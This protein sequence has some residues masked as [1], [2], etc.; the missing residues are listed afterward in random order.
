MQWFTC[1][2]GHTVWMAESM[3]GNSS[4]PME[5]HNSAAALICAVHRFSCPS[6]CC[7]LPDW[8]VSDSL[9]TFSSTV[10]SFHT[11]HQA[12]TKQCCIVTYCTFHSALDIS[13]QKIRKSSDTL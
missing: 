3:P 8:G 7:L 13:Q 10:F 4:S 9:K 1:G 11:T 6:P 12:N 5:Q 2:W